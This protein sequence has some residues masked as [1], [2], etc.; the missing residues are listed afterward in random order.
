MPD[1]K[2]S[3]PWEAL[4][5]DSEEV[6]EHLWQSSL[7]ALTLVTEDGYFRHPSEALCE[8]LEYTSSELERLK[9]ADVTHPADISSDIEMAKAVAE[10]RLS[11]YVMSKRYITK[12][13]RVVWI[14]LHV[15][16]FFRSDG[17]F[18]MFLSQIAPAEVYNPNAPAVARTIP[19][20]T[21]IREFIVK[22]WKWL[23]TATIL[24]VGAAY[25][26]VTFHNRMTDVLDEHERLTNE[27]K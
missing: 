2:V 9:F 17:K 13:A 18:L 6:A 7:I 26:V 16:G 4:G 10:G 19:I 3:P 22:H 24:T 23:I 21:R 14:K 5:L 27:N 20:E 12:T 11:H 25:E 15:S 8:L 1:P